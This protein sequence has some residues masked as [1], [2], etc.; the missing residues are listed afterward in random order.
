MS[1][2]QGER[3]FYFF[4]RIVLTNTMVSGQSTIIL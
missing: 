4:N 3:V 2:I 1:V